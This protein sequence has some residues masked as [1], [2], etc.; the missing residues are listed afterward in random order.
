MAVRP[1][2]AHAYECVS[3][4][5]ATKNACQIFR[6]TEHA[7]QWQRGTGRA[8]PA[9]WQAIGSVRICARFQVACIHC[10]ANGGELH[11]QLC[12]LFQDVRGLSQWRR[13]LNARF[14]SILLPFVHC[15]ASRWPAWWRPCGYECGMRGSVGHVSHACFPGW[16]WPGPYLCR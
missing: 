15:R 11:V 12:Y 2:L 9:F 14:Y 16:S 5:G 8:P 7:T 13:V 1:V 4:G 3:R 10:A 6:R